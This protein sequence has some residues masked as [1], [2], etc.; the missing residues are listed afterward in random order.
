MTTKA[1]NL[2]KP[3]WLFSI[4]LI[5]SSVVGLVLLVSILKDERFDFDY[6]L[7]IIV[8]II[9]H[10]VVGIGILS[11]KRWGFLIFKY[12]LY[13]LYLG[14]P[15]GTYISHKTLLYIKQNE[16]AKLYKGK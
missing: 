13:L 1:D 3:L 11:R 15:I 14:I 10:S 2:P 16:V 7:F 12:Y 4:I 9:L 6:S 5:A 8:M